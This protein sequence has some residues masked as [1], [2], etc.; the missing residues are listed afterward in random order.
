MSNILI[1]LFIGL[2]FVTNLAFFI[3]GINTRNTV[4]III[5]GIGLIILFAVVHYKNR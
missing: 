1:S 5:S 2:V 4:L 3:I